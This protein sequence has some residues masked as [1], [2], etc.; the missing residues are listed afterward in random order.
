MLGVLMYLG[1]RVIVLSLNPVSAFN[2][3]NAAKAC[4]LVVGE[5]NS[6]ILDLWL[7]VVFKNSI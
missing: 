6:I 2:M 4:S 3:A 7:R 1:C 5:W